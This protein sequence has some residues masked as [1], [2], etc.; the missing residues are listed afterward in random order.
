M[1]YLDSGTKEHEDLHRCKQ[2]LKRIKE[3]TSNVDVHAVC[4]DF[5]EFLS[6]LFIL[7]LEKPCDCIGRVVDE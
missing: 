3:V 5:E 7:K 2:Y 4:N 1:A 6:M